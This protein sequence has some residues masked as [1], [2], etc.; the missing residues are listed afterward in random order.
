MSHLKREDA[1]F[2]IDVEFSR[3]VEVEDGVEG[4]W[5]SIKEEL[6]IREAVV[7]DQLHDGRVC[8]HCAQAAQAGVGVLVS[9]GDY[10]KS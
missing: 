9:W 6:I 3:P 10:K 4:S 2:L 8:L 5:M 1:H 7:C